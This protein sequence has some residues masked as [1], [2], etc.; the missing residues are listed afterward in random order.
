M[1]TI[2]D[3]IK[4]GEGAT[5]GPLSIGEY[6]GIKAPGLYDKLSVAGVS[7]PCGNVRKDDVSNANRDF[8]VALVNAWPRLRAVVE[9]AK[10]CDDAYGEDEKSAQLLSNLDAALKAL[11]G[12]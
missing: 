8:I 5:P 11:E 7:I 2:T 12:A 10:A 1:T 9:A 4:L 6:G 3:L